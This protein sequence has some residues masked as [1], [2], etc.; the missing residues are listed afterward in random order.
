MKA[1]EDRLTEN[2]NETV[3]KEVVDYNEAAFKRIADLV[4]NLR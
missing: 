1:L 3:L 4:D 2:P